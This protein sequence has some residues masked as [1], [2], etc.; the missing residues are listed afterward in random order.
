MTVVIRVSDADRARAWGFL[1]RHS[2]G[3][4][5]P[6]NTF[7]ISEAAARGLRKAGIQFTEISR[8]R[9]GVGTR[10]VAERE[11]I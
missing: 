1:V 6:N 11:R 5:L 10:R 7:I 9:S 2:P 8:E 4:A 3:T